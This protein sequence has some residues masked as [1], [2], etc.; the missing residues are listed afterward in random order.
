[1]PQEAATTEKE[2]FVKRIFDCLVS[3][4]LLH[5]SLA[6]LEVEQAWFDDNDPMLLGEALKKAG[7]SSLVTFV[8]QFP[9]ELTI[10]RSA[11][12]SM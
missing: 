3:S 7:F 5:R 11:S 1:M 2:K 9:N 8:Q 12:L 6:Y 4:V 10:H